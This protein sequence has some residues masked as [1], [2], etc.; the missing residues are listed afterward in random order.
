[1][2]RIVALL[3]ILLFLC[4]GLLVPPLLFPVQ[5]AGWLLLGWTAFLYR[6]VPAMTVDWAGLATALLCLTALAVG[7]HYICSWVHQQIV[8]AKHPDQVAIARWRPR[9]TFALLALV[10]LMFVAGIAAVG[11]THQSYWLATAPE[12]LI[13]SSFG[14]DRTLSRMRLKQVGF[15]VL[16]YHETFHQLPGVTFDPQG[17][18][19]HG[20]QTLILPFIEEDNVFKQINRELPWS[21]ADNRPAFQTVIP[22]YLNPIASENTSPDGYG[23]S[24][25]AGN[26]RVL[27]T[28]APLRIASFTNGASKTI[29]AGEAR[30]SFKPWGHPTSWRDPGLGINKS[31]D[32]FGNPGD[33][34]SALLL[35]V[36]GSVRNV[37]ASISPEVL[38]A[39]AMPSGRSKIPDDWD[40]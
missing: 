35:M 11:M 3:G 37:M 16:D 6:V 1:M 40:E 39:L 4:C 29:L 27:G 13:E 19:L 22:G 14:V 24:H 36:D 5:V 18:A 8:R 23:L 2:K 26:V 28:N 38:K 25:Y 7:L 9:W 31:P 34:K 30:G 21:H 20:W 12:P 33:D 17:R 15:G 10:V 32:G